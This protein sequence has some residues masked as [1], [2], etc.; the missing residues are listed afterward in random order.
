MGHLEL[1]ALSRVLLLML[2]FG[3]LFVVP[4]ARICS[5]VGFSPWLGLLALLPV[6]NLGLLRFVAF[7]AWPAHSVR[8]RGA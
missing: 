5:R 4:A 8:E 2:L 6:A 1:L 7:A 3:V